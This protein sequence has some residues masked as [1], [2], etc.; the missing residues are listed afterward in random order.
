MNVLN[1][2]GY[3][4][5][6]A[7]LRA[8]K[9]GD[10]VTQFSVAMT[11]GYKERQKTTWVRCTLFGKRGESLAPYLL[12]G[13]LIG[14]SGEAALHSWTNNDGE[15]KTSLECTVRDVTLLAPPK[16]DQPARTERTREPQQAALID[17]DIPF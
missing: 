6:D 4:G 1:F 16:G 9:N 15:T 7:E 3:L 10:M 5:G 11:S 17:D 13:A 14:V 12:K 2:T 8:T